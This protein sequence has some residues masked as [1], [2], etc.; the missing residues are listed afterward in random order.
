MTRGEQCA[1]TA[2]VGLTELSTAHTGQHPMWDSAHVGQHPVWDTAHVGHRPVSSGWLEAFVFHTPG[3]LPLHTGP[4][5]CMRTHR[6]G[7]Y[8]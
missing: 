2:G 8:V 3:C 6:G 4:H 1:Q 7:A 5:V